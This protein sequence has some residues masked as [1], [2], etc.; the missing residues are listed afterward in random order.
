MV[1]SVVFN[2]QKHHTPTLGSFAIPTDSSIFSLCAHPNDHLGSSSTSVSPREAT[3]SSRRRSAFLR[4][5]HLL[6]AAT[7]H[8]C[9]AAHPSYNS[10]PRPLAL[11]IL[12]IS[13]DPLVCATVS[14]VR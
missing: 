14:S 11:D 9:R 6:F 12:S 8:L 4:P 3:A 2:T 5:F 13:L 1:G 10:L 7:W